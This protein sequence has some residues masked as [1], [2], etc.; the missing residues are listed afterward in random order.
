MSDFDCPACSKEFD[1]ESHMIRHVKD[2]HPMTY[3]GMM[4][5]RELE[6]ERGERGDDYP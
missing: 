4:T 2:N 6:R 5:D 1:Y 3:M